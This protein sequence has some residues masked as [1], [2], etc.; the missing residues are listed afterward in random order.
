MPA[1]CCYGAKA[2]KTRKAART[3]RRRSISKNSEARA[4]R[5]HAGWIKGPDA[6]LAEFQQAVALSPTNEIAYQSVG[7][8]QRVHDG[9]RKPR[10]PSGVIECRDQ[11][12]FSSHGARQLPM[13]P[14]PSS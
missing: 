8:M 2:E 13:G 12:G 11:V 10:P 14:G 9:V 4:A 6:A 7:V 3:P 5:K 1:I